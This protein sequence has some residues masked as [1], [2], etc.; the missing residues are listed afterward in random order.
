ME[1]ER[2]KWV[3]INTFCMPIRRFAF[4]ASVG[5]AIMPVR[6]IRGVSCGYTLKEAIRTIIL[7]KEGPK[8]KVTCRDN[9]PCYTVKGYQ[10]VAVNGEIVTQK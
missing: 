2:L 9:L 8:V 7:E 1:A 6:K 3:K 5:I 10:L 4:R